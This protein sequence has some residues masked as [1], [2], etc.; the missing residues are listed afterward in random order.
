MKRFLSYLG[1][2]LGACLFGNVQG[3]DA[4]VTGKYLPAV[5]ARDFYSGY[6][7]RSDT[8]YLPPE[9]DA[10]RFRGGAE[11]LP[12]RVESPV[13][14]PPGVYRPMEEQRTISPQIGAYRFRSISPEEQA[15][16]DRAETSVSGPGANQA[17]RQFD[18][19]VNEH[20]S[21]GTTPTPQQSY[22]FRPDER[23]PNTGN[24]QRFRP[25]LSDPSQ[26][27]PS[28]YTPPVFRQE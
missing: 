27:Y 15:R 3:Q 28:G 14:L 19:R 7:W 26:S 20:R 13:G 6:Q 16:T 9:T 4:A 25:Y 2:V 11:L 5:P 18:Y 17:A 1:C 10:T 12:G 23:F 22:R 8:G 24:R 21:Y